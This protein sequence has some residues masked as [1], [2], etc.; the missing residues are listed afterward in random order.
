MVSDTEKR[1]AQFSRL[2]IKQTEDGGVKPSL[3]E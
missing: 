3:L 1:K 2:A